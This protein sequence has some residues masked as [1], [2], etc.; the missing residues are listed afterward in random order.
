[1]SLGFARETALEN[2][3]LIVPPHFTNAI[4][5]GQTGSG[6]TTGFILP[7]IK[8]RMAQNHG[9]LI[10]DFKGN[11]HLKIK[12]MAHSLG[13]MHRIKEIG[14]LWGASINLLDG[15]NE[16]E[17]DTLLAT[18]H[19][20]GYWDIAA[21]SLF[22]IVYASLIQ[23][24]E[25]GL[26]SKSDYN[27]YSFLESF[28]IK[29][30]FSSIRETLQPDNIDELATKMKFVKNHLLHKVSF[31]S[32]EYS[33]EI[34]A[35]LKHH[36]SR[37]FELDIEMKPFLNLKK[38][39]PDSGNKA[40]MYCLIN[41]IN[42]IS[43]MRI[44]NDPNAKTIGELVEENIVIVSHDT[45]GDMA[46][47]IINARLFA[48]LKKRAGQASAKPVT[49]FID[50]AHK[51]LSEHTLPEVSVCRES[52]FEYIMSVQDQSLLAE[53]IGTNACEGLLVNIA[54]VLSFKNITDERSL[55]LEPFMCIR[56]DNKSSHKIKAVPLFIN[57]KEEI[58][59]QKAFQKEFDLLNAFTFVNNIKGYL[60]SDA[61]LFLSNKAYFIKD[62]GRREMIGIYRND[63][64]TKEDDRGIKFPPTSLNQTESLFNENVVFTLMQEQEKLEN[65][66]SALETKYNYVQ[67]DKNESVI[68][69]R[70]QPDNNEVEHVE[71]FKTT[72][73]IAKMLM[74]CTPQ[75]DK[76][77]MLYKRMMEYFLAVGKSNKGCGLEA[78]KTNNY[79]SVPFD[80][81]IDLVL[82]EAQKTVKSD[83]LL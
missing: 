37:L 40:V 47:R 38:S 44:L 5:Y 59:A 36:A 18:S 67:M 2:V 10:F 11:V 27:L 3:S 8:E 71:F 33:P 61:D 77:F 20:S 4:C 56:L 66:I 31:Q 24:Y 21:K 69:L 53:K 63:I 17:I 42:D 58:K 80:Y 32:K 28:S 35:A 52:R 46:S 34:L 65:K 81:M 64:Q 78:L 19:S 83:R 29:P 14:T 41:T 76:E 6:K 7:N 73:E 22:K 75:D 49:I 68:K 62:D 72:P 55:M 50:E 13:Q 51:V 1:M 82:V 25:I 74:T 23:L 12:A 43:R 48:H 39:D 45:I 30:T 15:L 9:M 16:K 54:Y 26:L 57:E 70:Y 60:Q 79:N